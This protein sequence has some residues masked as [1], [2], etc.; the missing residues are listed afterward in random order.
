VVA[1]LTTEVRHE[2]TLRTLGMTFTGGQLP[3]AWTTDALVPAGSA[4][5]HTTQIAFGARAHVAVISV[6][7]LLYK[8]L[9]D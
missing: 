9:H 8:I 3:S 7:T 4:A 1:F 5:R 2:K 6:N